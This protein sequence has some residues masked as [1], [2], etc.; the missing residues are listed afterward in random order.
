MADWRQIHIG[1]FRKGGKT[2]VVI[3]IEPFINLSAT[4]F[5]RTKGLDHIRSI[6]GIST[7]LAKS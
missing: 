7:P 3:S 2:A 6:V 1:P 4:G 5:Q